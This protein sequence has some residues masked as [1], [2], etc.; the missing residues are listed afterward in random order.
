LELVERARKLVEEQILARC[1]VKSVLVDLGRSNCIGD[2]LADLNVGLAHIA[3]RGP[4][5]DL[6]G[7]LR[8]LLQLVN[9]SRRPP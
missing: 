2:R 7:K 8:E 6:P 9:Q 3:R 1:A 4:F 5:C